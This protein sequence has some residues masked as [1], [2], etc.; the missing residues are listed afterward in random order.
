MSEVTKTQEHIPSQAIAE[1]STSNVEVDK[2]IPEPVI[3]ETSTTEPV[4]ESATPAQA[5][6]PEETSGEKPKE[7]EKS[8]DIARSIFKGFQS[9]LAGVFPKKTEKSSEIKEEKREN[10]SDIKD[11]I[12]EEDKETKETK[13][14][15]SASRKRNSFFGGLVLG[16]KDDKSEVD[17]TTVTATNKD[18]STEPKKSAEA[19]SEQPAATEV[20]ASSE[21]PAEKPA[22]PFKRASIFGTLKNQFARKEKSETSSAPKETESSATAPVIPAV[23]TSDVPTT[24]EAITEAIIDKTQEI[25]ATV[26]SKTEKLAA[27]VERRKSTLPFGLGLGKKEKLVA[28]DDEACEKPLSPFARI[29]A[30]VRSKTSPKHAPEKKEELPIT[31]ED[32]TEEVTPQPLATEPEPAVTTATPAVAAS[33]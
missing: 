31:A 1:T 23:G 16:K 3:Q 14:R 12:K 10:V 22:G 25:Q 7:S 24:E 19:N 33:A 15:R 26:D 27:K 17:D 18:T 32:K 8:D 11:D 28:S 29:R 5:S 13:E 4:P 9:K 21:A 6:A 20:P 30:T 2:S